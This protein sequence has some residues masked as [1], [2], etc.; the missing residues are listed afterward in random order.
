MKHMDT[1]LKL[2]KLDL[3]Q[4]LMLI[5]DEAS[6]QRVLD[7]GC[8][9]E[10][11]LFGGGTGHGS[12]P[13]GAGFTAEGAPD[14]FKVL[15]A[16]QVVASAWFTRLRRNFSSVFNDCRLCS[17]PGRL[18]SPRSLRSGLSPPPA[19]PLGRRWGG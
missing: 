6:L 8:W 7:Q 4:R 14:D 10:C 15:K 2:K 17:M 18:F 19:S 3:M 16:G 11:L 12:D 13:A 5:W 1:A 9:S